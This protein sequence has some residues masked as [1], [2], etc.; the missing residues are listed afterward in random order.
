MSRYGKKTSPVPWIAAGGLLIGFVVLVV[1]TTGKDEPQPAA[2][3][4]PPI[5]AEAPVAK[6]AAPPPAPEPGLT[7]AEADAY[8]RRAT[9]EWREFTLEL[10][11]EEKWPSRRAV[12]FLEKVT[13]NDRESSSS[14]TWPSCRTCGRRS[15]SPRSTT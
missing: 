4:N 7:A 8:L 13:W 6:E 5:V 15:H 9:A 14:S 3:T 12:A 10:C 2:P 1:V 11:R